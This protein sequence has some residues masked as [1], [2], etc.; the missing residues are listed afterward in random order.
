MSTSIPRCEYQWNGTTKKPAIADFF[1][2]GA[3]VNHRYLVL[4]KS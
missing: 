4:G 3:V 1:V 2:C